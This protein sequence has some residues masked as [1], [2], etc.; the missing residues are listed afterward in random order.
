MRES[1]SVRLNASAVGVALVALLLVAARPDAPVADA[2]S[3]GDVEAVR[4]P[5]S[6]TRLASMNLSSWPAAL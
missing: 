5:R 2:A 3:R 4:E 1:R 6:K